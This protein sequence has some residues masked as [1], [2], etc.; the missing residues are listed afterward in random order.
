[1]RYF[2]VTLIIGFG[3]AL[4]GMGDARAGAWCATTLTPTTAGS[5]R[6]SNARR[7]CWGQ[8]A[9]ARATSTSRRPHGACGRCARPRAIESVDV[10]A[11]GE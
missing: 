6:S 1:M 2:A 11:R 8:A 4:A 5:T 7:P 3:F 9:I 10:V